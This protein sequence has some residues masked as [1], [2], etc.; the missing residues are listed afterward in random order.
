MVHPVHFPRYW[1]GLNSSAASWPNFNWVDGYSPGPA[2]YAPAFTNWGKDAAGV[3][4]PNNKT[5]GF[6]VVA[7][8]LEAKNITTKLTY[9]WAWNDQDCNLNRPSMCWQPPGARL[10]RPASPGSACLPLV[11]L[12]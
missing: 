11:L 8:Y 7:D 1:I 9:N 10:W 2:N 4:E 12:M 5:H 3:A 6:C